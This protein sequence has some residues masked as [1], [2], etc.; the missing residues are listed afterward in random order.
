MD[1]LCHRFYYIAHLRNLASISHFGLLSHNAMIEKGI[2]HVDIA[3]PGAQRWR[4]RP[5][6]VYGRSIHEYVPLYI[7]PRN[8][9][10]YLRREWHKEL[11]ILKI[12]ASVV[13]NCVHV[14]TDGNAASHSTVFSS[15]VSVIA[16]SKPALLA[17]RWTDFADGKRQSCAELLVYPSVQ[18]MYFEGAL[19]SNAET[20]ARVKEITSLHAAVDKPMFFQVPT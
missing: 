2:R 17:K 18:R 1:D 12:S 16:N 8:P 10:L 9:M 3:D 14:F 4:D 5:E 7:N 11:V 19:C 20:A 15:E 13:T 6:P